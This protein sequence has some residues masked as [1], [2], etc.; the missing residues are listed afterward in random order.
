[1]TE[2]A[3]LLS[4]GQDCPGQPSGGN[5]DR[6]A[7]NAEQ[8]LPTRVHKRHPGFLVAM[9]SYFKNGVEVLTR[10]QWI[11]PRVA[12]ERFVRIEPSVHDV[13][14]RSR[15]LDRGPLREPA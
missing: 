7:F 10:A 9:S 8:R 2:V 11:E 4:A 14:R 12:R 15:P 5:L 6:L 3:D 13:R 1:M